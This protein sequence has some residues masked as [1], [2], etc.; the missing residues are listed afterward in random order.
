MKKFTSLC[1]LSE[2]TLV[3]L[4][5]RRVATN[6]SEKQTENSE[7]GMCFD[8]GYVWSDDSRLI[9]DYHY[10]DDDK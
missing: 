4:L 7:S 9:G 8:D 10:F 5:F 1:M 6:L 2:W 3:L